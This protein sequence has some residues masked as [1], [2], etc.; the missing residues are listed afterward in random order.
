MERPPSGSRH[1]GQSSVSGSS[2][3]P[4]PALR[5]KAFIEMGSLPVAAL[6]NRWD[7]TFD[8]APGKSRSRGAPSC[9][10]L[11]ERFVTVL[12]Q[13]ERLSCSFV[14][15]PPPAG[16]LRFTEQAHRAS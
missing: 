1:F 8:A 16:H 12:P 11:G 9:R 10:I 3:E 5:I 7:L 6:K 13:P 15:S 2:R 14:H 4:C